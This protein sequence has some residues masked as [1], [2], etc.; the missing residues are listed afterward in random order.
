MIVEMRTAP[1]YQE[2]KAADIPE[3]KDGDGTPALLIRMF[4]FPNCAATSCSTRSTCSSLVT[5]AGKTRASPPAAAIS[6]PTP[7]SYSQVLEISVMAIFSRRDEISM[8]FQSSS[9]C[10]S[11]GASMNP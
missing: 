11:F 9:R 5:S 10:A 4:T 8:L 3:I 6:A 2:V 1:R 7:S